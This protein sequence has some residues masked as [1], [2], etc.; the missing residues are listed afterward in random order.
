VEKNHVGNSSYTGTTL[1]KSANILSCHPVCAPHA[2]ASGKDEPESLVLSW[3]MEG[4]RS[5]GTQFDLA[6]QHSANYV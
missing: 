5:V 3:D 2:S 1:G 6:L 4:E